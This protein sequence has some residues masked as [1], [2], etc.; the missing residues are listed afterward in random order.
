MSISSK[1]RVLQELFWGEKKEKKKLVDV[2]VFFFFLNKDFF[3]F[4][5]KKERR[6]VSVGRFSIIMYDS[7]C[8]ILLIPLLLR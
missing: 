8:P 2:V 3:D 7:C 5:A 4:V 6:D 1:Q